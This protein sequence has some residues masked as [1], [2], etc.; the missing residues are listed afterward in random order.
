MEDDI[1]EDFTSEWN[2]LVDSIIF[3]ITREANE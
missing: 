3:D 2:D 1:S